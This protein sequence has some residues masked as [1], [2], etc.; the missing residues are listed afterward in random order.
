MPEGYR[1]EESLGE[2]YNGKV[3]FINIPIFIESTCNRADPHQGPEDFRPGCGPAQKYRGPRTAQCVRHGD[4]V[5][6]DQL[7]IRDFVRKEFSE[8]LKKELAREGV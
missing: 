3:I 4:H 5:R 7:A 2:S 6:Q 8:G 1:Q